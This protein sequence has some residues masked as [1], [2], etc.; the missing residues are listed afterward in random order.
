MAVLLCARD[1]EHSA[2]E[3]GQEARA[4]TGLGGALAPKVRAAACCGRNGGTHGTSPGASPAR[5][6]PLFFPVNNS[7]S[8]LEGA[9]CSPARLLIR[10]PHTPRYRAELSEGRAWR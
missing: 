4:K 3:M 8:A 9:S 2:T 10:S 1:L 7:V 6:D 5:P